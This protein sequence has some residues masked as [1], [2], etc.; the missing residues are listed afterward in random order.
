MLVLLSTLI[1]G[2]SLGYILGGRLRN[3]ERLDLRLGWVVL[4]SLALQFWAFSPWGESQGSAVVVT[5]HYASYALLVVFVIANYRRPALVL[6][7]AGMLFNLLAIGLNGGYMPARRAALEFAGVAYAGNTESNSQ[8]ITGST[9]LAFLG[10][11]FAL[12]DWAPLANVFSIGDVLIVVG[13]TALIA[14]GMRGPRRLI[15]QAA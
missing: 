1:L 15:A 11:V 13:A 5:A 12:P 3:L 6:T 7:G 14:G 10:D 8:L 2:V 9:K 4:L